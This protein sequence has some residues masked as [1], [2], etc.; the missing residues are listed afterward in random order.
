MIYDKGFYV[1]V[2]NSPAI[3]VEDLW[4]S[5][6]SNPVLEDVNISVPRGDF[7]SIVGPNGGGK[8]TLLKLILGLL[9]PS[10]GRALVFGEEPE[11]ARRRIGYMPQHSQLDPEFPATVMDVAL[12]GRLGHGRSFGPYSKGDKEIVTSVLEQVGLRDFRKKPFAAISGG[13]RQ[14][15]FIARA[16]ACEPEILLLDEPTASLDVVMEGDLY[17][18]LQTL[19]DRL[20]IVMVSHDLGF[21]SS[22]VKSV[23]CVKRKV[24]MHPTAEITGA[25]INEIYGSPMRMIRHNGD[26]NLSCPNS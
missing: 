19:N 18:L 16:L 23:I 25:I 7:V 12:M 21:V 17:E 4:F 2:T 13:Q 20:T 26:R 9:K 14:R 10:R 11:Q 5:Y 3:F 1:N 8:T 24:L 22:I 15:L 6:D